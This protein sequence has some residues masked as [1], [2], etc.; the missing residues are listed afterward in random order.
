MSGIDNRRAARIPVVLPVNLDPMGSAGGNLIAKTKDFSS[1]GVSFEF[2]SPIEV[3][4]ELTFIL[5]L[6]EQITHGKPVRIKCKGKVVRVFRARP[7]SA[8][9]SVAA[10]IERYEEFLAVP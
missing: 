6:P 3:G 8:T 1:N 10:T 2:S 4:S 7:E 9:L 5:I